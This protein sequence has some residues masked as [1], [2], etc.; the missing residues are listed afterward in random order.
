MQYDQKRKNI[1]KRERERNEVNLSERKRRAVIICRHTVFY[2]D[3]IREATGTLLQLIR[4]FSKAA[5]RRSI[6]TNQ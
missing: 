4:V 6:N 2:L 3:N 1:K 5:E